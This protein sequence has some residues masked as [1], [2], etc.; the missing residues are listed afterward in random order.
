VTWENIGGPSNA[1]D[2]RTVCAVTNNIVFAIGSEGSIWRT[3]NSG[4][5]SVNTSSTTYHFSSPVLIIEP[6]PKTDITVPITVANAIPGTGFTLIVHDDTFQYVYK[7]SFALNN[8]RIDVPAQSWPG[9]AMMQFRPTDITKDSGM[10]GYSVFV[11]KNSELFYDTVRFDSAS[12]GASLCGP[13]IKGNATETIIGKYPPATV[14]SYD[15]HSAFTVRPNP[16]DGKFVIHSSGESYNVAISVLDILGR[17][18]S[19]RGQEITK[20]RPAIID[21]SNEVA[22]TYYIRIL[23]DGII[24]TISVVKK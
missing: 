7:G 16:S 24:Q 10:I 4:G 20:E 14:D 12:A 13:G 8:D 3:I 5:D 2:T 22:G 17:V 15:I 23:H 1:I 21:L 18:I 9:R 19:D 6:K 11:L